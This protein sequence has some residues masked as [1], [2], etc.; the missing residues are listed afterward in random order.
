MQIDIAGCFQLEPALIDNPAQLYSLVKT[1][2][3]DF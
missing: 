1:V 3:Q 2:E